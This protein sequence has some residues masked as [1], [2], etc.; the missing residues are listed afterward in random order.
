MLG[1]HPN[2]YWG[3]ETFNDKKIGRLYS[4]YNTLN[5][6]KA[7]RLQSAMA[8]GRIF[9]FEIKGH[10]TQHPENIGETLQD[11]IAGAYRFGCR[12][13]ILL[14][15]AHVLRRFVSYLVG[16]KRKQWNYKR[17]ERPEKVKVRV[18]IT[19][20]NEQAGV[21]EF[22]ERFDGIGERWKELI[23]DDCKT[24]ELE[25]ARD[26]LG[27]PRDAYFRVAGWLGLDEFTPTVDIRKGGTEPL[28][29][30]VKNWNEVREALSGTPHAWM[31]TDEAAELDRT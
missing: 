18:P 16:S 26:I 3:S 7:L 2:V 15:R 28:D 19:S 17:D 12:H 10:P 29:S 30:V 6:W 20:S 8:K 27:T 13:F 11:T 31:L 1:Q 22:I 5:P 4:A 23:P 14:T 24:I 25:Y 21:L 9:G